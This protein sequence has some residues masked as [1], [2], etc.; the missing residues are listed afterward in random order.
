ML[1]QHQEALFIMKNNE[2][3]N[4]LVV[5]GIFAKG[6][7]TVGKIVMQDRRM[8]PQSKAIYSYFCTYAGAGT[9][10]FPSVAKIMYDLNMSNKT[11][12]KHFK[13]L[14]EFGYISVFQRK[15]EGKF[16]KNLYKINM[17]PKK[18]INPQK[19]EQGGG[20]ETVPNEFYYDWMA[21]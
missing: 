21:D 14:V 15:S 20:E 3:E 9:T 6:F 12:Y 1:I 8:T 13:P 18:L 11:Y 2:I 10:A 4:V 17:N 16:Q 19:E 7:G 5:E